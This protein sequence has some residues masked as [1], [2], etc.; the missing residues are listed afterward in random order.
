VLVYFGRWDVEMNCRVPAAC[1]TRHATPSLSAEHPDQ[2][3]RS[4]LARR[5]QLHLVVIRLL[6]HESSHELFH[7]PSDTDG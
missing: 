2:L 5:R 1:D 3:R 7:E 4:I 6:A